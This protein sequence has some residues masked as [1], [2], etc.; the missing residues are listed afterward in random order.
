LP[1]DG[2]S[3]EDIDQMAAAIVEVQRVTI[4]IARALPEIDTDEKQA[5]KRIAALHAEHEKAAKELESATAEA[6]EQLSKINAAFKVAA[7]EGL[8]LDN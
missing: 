2:V 8:G 7:R 5:R 1:A 3:K 6:K 4:E